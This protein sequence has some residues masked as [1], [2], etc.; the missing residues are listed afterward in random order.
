MTGLTTFVAVTN[1]S[2]ATGI[3]I[4][5]I[6]LYCRFMYARAPSWMARAISRMAG[7][8]SS[9]A[10]T[11]RINNSAVTREIRAQTK[12]KTSHHHSV[13]RRVNAW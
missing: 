9:A 11:L 10:R 3:T 6:V 1:T 8:P 2:T 12:A 7:V 5:P 4:R 13:P